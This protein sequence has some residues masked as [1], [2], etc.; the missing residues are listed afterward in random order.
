LSKYPCCVH[1]VLPVDRVPESAPRGHSVVPSGTHGAYREDIVLPA[2]SVVAA[3][4]DATDIEAA[5]LPMNGLTA[6]QVLDQPDLDSGRVLAVT[7]APALSAA[8]WCRWPSRGP[9]RGR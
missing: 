3:P 6:L 7:G 8:T 1:P 5:P 2:R 9:D 4:A